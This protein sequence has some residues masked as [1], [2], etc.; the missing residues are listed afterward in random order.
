MSKFAIYACTQS[1]QVCPTLCDPLEPTRLLCPWDS[2]GKNTGVGCHALLQGDLPNPGIQPASLMSPSLAGEFFPTNT[3][4]EAP[5]ICESCTSL[6]TG[7]CFHLSYLSRSRIPGLHGH[8]TFNLIRSGKIVF[9]NDFIAL[10]FQNKD[11]VLF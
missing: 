9:Q 7:I 5:A 2:P 11:M 8:Y 10:L 4:W 3:T 6:S 1:F